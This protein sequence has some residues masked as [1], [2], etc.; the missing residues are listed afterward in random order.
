MAS[1]IEPQEYL[2]SASALMKLGRG[3][4]AQ[5]G[6]GPGGSVTDGIV[7]GDAVVGSVGQPWPLMIF[8]AGQGA[9]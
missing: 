1:N 7:G 5:S 9:G 2:S 8:D 6:T 4:E 3:G